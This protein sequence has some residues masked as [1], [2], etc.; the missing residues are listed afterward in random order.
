MRH[1]IIIL[2]ATITF[3]SCKTKN[4]GFNISGHIEGIKDSILITLY[5]LD[6]Q[7]NLD[8]AFSI[9]GYFELSGKVEYPTGCWIKCQDEYANIQ[10]ENVN[11]S[12]TSPIKDMH[13]NSLVLSLVEQNKNYKMN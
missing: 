4:D 9:N 6:Q 13:L 5:D 2:I 12:F 1:L 7:I 11:M 8:S 10:V 3:S